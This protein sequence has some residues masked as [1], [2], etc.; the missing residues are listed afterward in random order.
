MPNADYL[1]WVASLAEVKTTVPWDFQ[2]IGL[3]AQRR[4]LDLLT[5][6]TP[7]PNKV[8]VGLPGLSGCGQGPYQRQRACED[9]QRLY[10]WPAFYP[11]ACCP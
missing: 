10:H 1:D 7:G 5:I 6:G 9:G 8:K 2:Q 11:Q 3:S 4:P